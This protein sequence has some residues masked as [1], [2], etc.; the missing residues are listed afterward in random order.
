MTV[1]QVCAYSAQYGG[2][3]LASLKALDMELQKQGFRTIYLFPE[4]A[5]DKK[6][7]KDL[8]REST[9]YFASSNRFGIKTFLQIKKAVKE[10]DVVHSH[11]ELYDCL[12]AL[13]RRKQQKLIWHLH[14]SFDEKTDWA[15]RVINWMQY[16][17][18]GF[19]AVLI[20]P[21][22]YYADYVVQMGFP[23]NNVYIVDNCLD[24]S[25]LAKDEPQRDIKYDFLVY[26]GFYEIKGL[27]VVLDAARMLAQKGYRFSIGIV[28]YQ[29]TWTY[30]DENYADLENYIIREEP[31]ENVSQF[32]RSAR[33]FISAS[34]R[35]TFSYAMLEALFMGLPVICSDI[36]GTQWAW[37]YQNS[38]H[39]ESGNVAELTLWMESVLNNQ[40]WV[41]LQQSKETTKDIEQ[42]YNIK[43]WTKQIKGIYLGE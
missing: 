7:C 30:I 6:W 28:G 42:R 31:S 32:Y 24:C 29:K 3:F 36:V 9:V 10:A 17:L 20:S 18:L 40:R 38:K 43:L 2:N 4:Q 37:K 22:R 13:A 27:D 12:C 1:L 34:R 11:F 21:S 25:R 15:H 35:E 8:Q 39:F 16:G 26:G 5:K 33:V 19:N 41:T 14:D 23:S